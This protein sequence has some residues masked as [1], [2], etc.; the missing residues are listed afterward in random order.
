[1]DSTI[2][3]EFGSRL[4]TVTPPVAEAW[5][6]IRAG[7]LLPVVDG[8]LAATALVHGLVVVSRDVTTAERAGVP[9]LDPWAA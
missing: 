8:L 3:A 4:L 9:W 1:M 7:A 2:Q 5:G 6:R